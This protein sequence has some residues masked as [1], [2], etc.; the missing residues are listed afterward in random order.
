MNQADIALEQL[1]LLACC[2]AAPDS[3]SRGAQEIFCALSLRDFAGL[4]NKPPIQT[5][6]MCM[7]ASEKRAADLAGQC[8][9]VMC[10]LVMQCTHYGHNLTVN[11]AL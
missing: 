10:S 9:V 8:P 4:H 3:K 7:R 1:L 11:T 6:Q 2:R 5:C